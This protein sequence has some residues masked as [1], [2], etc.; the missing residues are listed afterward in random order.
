MNYRKELNKY[1]IKLLVQAPA[2]EIKDN[3]RNF[4]INLSDISQ[5]QACLLLRELQDIH[6]LGNLHSLFSSGFSNSGIVSNIQNNALQGEMSIEQLVSHLGVRIPIGKKSIQIIEDPVF[7]QQI[8]EQETITIDCP[9]IGTPREHILLDSGG[10]RICRECVLVC[11]KCSNLACRKCTKGYVN[12][13][14]GKVTKAICS[15]HSA[16]ERFW[17]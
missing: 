4:I 1:L 6:G 10:H 13:E 2:E 9:H 14:T 5:E 8:I 16:W 11:N 7:G 3:I 15:H 17:F 12:T